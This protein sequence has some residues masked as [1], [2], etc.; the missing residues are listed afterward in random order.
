MP[1]CS[2]RMGPAHMKATMEGC[3][4]V[5]FTVTQQMC[6]L[7]TRLRNKQASK[8]LSIRFFWIGKQCN[9]IYYYHISLIGN[10]IDIL[11]SHI[12]PQKIRSLENKNYL[13]IRW[14]NYI[15][16]HIDF[17]IVRR[18]NIDPANK[19]HYYQLN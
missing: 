9:I 18:N 4:M 5:V 3:S 15:K 19:L 11:L 10:D 6:L 1:S 13:L 7:S 12:P 2:P 8:C 16:N 17:S 14:I